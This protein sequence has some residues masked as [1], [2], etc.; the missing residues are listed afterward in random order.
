M[1]GR[2]SWA[3]TER[4]AYSTSEWMMLSRWTTT[5]IFEAGRA[6]RH[7]APPTPLPLF[8]SERQRD[9]LPG[10]DRGERGHEPGAA[11]DGR[12]DEISL[13]QRGSLP[14][15]IRPAQDRRLQALAPRAQA[16]RGGLVGHGDDGRGERPDLLFELVHVAV[17]READRLE[18]LGEFADDVQGVGA[19]G[20][21]GTQ[22]DDPLHALFL[23]KV[24]SRGGNSR[25]PVL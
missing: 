12:D 4:S 21:G 23:R 24:A 17:G 7:P 6:E 1:S 14:E 18:L 8:T 9:E 25:I 2:P 10:R 19:D 5:S 3:I 13:R 16:L 22:D 20:A 11:D 15:P